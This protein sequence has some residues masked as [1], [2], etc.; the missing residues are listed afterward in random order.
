MISV[1][2]DLDLGSEKS[3]IA[4][5]INAHE[6]MSESDSGLFIYGE[7]TIYYNIIRKPL[8]SDKHKPSSK[9][10]IKVHP[11]LRVVVS[12]PTD[13]SKSE[14]EKAVMQRSRWIWNNMQEFA[15]QRED[16]LPRTYISGE[17]LFYLGKRYVLKV[18]VDKEQPPNVKLNRG[19]LQVTLR[20]QIS[21]THQDRISKVKPLLDKWY[22]D[23]AQAMFYARL[24]ELL[25]KATWVK[26]IPSFRILAMQKQWGSC[27]TSGNLML[28]PHLIKAPKE[29]IDYVILHELCHIAEHNHSERF[30]RLL[31]Q[32]MPNW[33]NVKAKLDGMAEMYLNE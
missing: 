18:I 14:I 12:A 6:D 9:I 27:S 31:T 22:Q 2:D 33:K 30:W 32:V 11:D 20:Q 26:G 21:D 17:T 1:T 13:A 29:C 23:K 3:A 10:G 15:K 28:N 8:P 16:V 7:D 24:A 4:A 19:Q 5:S 25:P